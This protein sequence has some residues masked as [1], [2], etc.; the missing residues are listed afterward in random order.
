MRTAMAEDAKIRSLANEVTRRMVTMFL[1]KKDAKYWT[2]MHRNS[3]Y[4]L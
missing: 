2:P 4:K 1:M 3:G